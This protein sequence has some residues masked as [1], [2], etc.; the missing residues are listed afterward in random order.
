MVIFI[1]DTLLVVFNFVSI[2][3]IK[4]SGDQI[5]LEIEPLNSIL[6][7]FCLKTMC[8]KVGDS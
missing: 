1:T 4:L 3:D 6:C 5:E 2:N 8:E 7:I